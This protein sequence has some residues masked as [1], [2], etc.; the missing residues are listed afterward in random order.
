MIAEML[1]MDI[2]FIFENDPGNTHYMITPYSFSPRLGRKMIPPVQIDL[3]QGVLRTIE[4]IHH[5][6]NPGMQNVGGYLLKDRT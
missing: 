6:L 2:N 3:G 4:E 1:D 5:E